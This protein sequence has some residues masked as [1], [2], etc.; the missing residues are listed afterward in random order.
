[1][2]RTEACEGTTGGG[3]PG[4]SLDDW[5]RTFVCTSH[6]PVFQIMYD[7]RYLA[8]NPYLAA[9]AAAIRISPGGYNTKVSRIS[10]NEPWRVVRTRM[11]TTGIEPPHPTEGAEPSG[12]F[13]AATGVTAYAATPGRRSTVATCSLARFPITLS[14]ARVLSRT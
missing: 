1:D 4:M 12:Y 10:P 13:S 9:P 2:R 11:R 8:R 5:G 3:R 6:D 7:G 14:T